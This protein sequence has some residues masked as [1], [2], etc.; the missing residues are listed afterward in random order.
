MGVGY[1][2]PEEGNKELWNILNQQI[3]QGKGV[4]NDQG[5]LLK[6]QFSNSNFAP[7]SYTPDIAQQNKD[8]LEQSL[9]NTHQG[10]QL[11]NQVDPSAGNIRQGLSSQIAGLTDPKNQQSMNNQWLKTTGAPGV[12][13]SGAKGT[14]TS[15]GLF[16]KGTMQGQQN[17]MNLLKTQQNY[18]GN[19]LSIGVSPNSSVSQRGTA[20]LSNQKNN[21][22]YLGGALSAANN[23]GQSAN[24]FN[25]N[26]FNSLSQLTENNQDIWRKEQ[27]GKD[28]ANAQ[29]MKNM[30]DGISTAVKVIGMVA[31]A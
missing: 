6:E 11:E 23:Y 28:E 22:N 21:Q 10:A 2:K 14:I 4:L 20:Q 8:L 15:S 13:G 26:A 5:G 9:I 17:L 25:N 30:I 29:S 12:Y 3:G 16:D 19:P 7:K 31:A 18:I 27:K 24:D 1:T